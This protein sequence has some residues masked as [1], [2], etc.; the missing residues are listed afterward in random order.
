MVNSAT[1][2]GENDNCPA[3]VLAV[4]HNRVWVFIREDHRE[5]KADGR[6]AFK[7][8]SLYID[9]VITLQT[10]KALL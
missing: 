7:K 4:R 9:L 1:N 6:E 2:R 5:I 10:K 8:W 3:E